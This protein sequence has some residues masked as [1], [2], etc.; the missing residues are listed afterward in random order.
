MKMIMRLFLLLFFAMALGGPANAAGQAPAGG[1]A[2]A[3]AVS[4]PSVQVP[5]TSYNFGEL[6]DGNEYVHDFKIRN[7]GT[8]TLEI[9]K[10]LPG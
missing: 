2:A 4:G 3:P 6:I 10:V 1:Q 7:V 9:K 8:A 5:E